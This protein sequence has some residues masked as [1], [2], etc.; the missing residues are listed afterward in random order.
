[1]TLTYQPGVL[2]PASPSGRSL[3][4]SLAHERDPRPALAR[5]REN[6]D[7]QW[8]VVGLGE[9]LVRALGREISGLRVFPALSGS[10]HAI[11]STQQDLW[12]FLRA[13]DRGA[14]F[15]LSRKVFDLLDG[16]FEP[17]DAMDTFSYAGGRDLSGYQDGTAN[18]GPQESLDVA[19]AGEAFAA[20]GSSFVAVQRWV[21]DLKRFFTH[22]VAERDAMIGRRHADNEEIDGAPESSHVKRTAQETFAPTAF[23]VRR[24]QPW[25]TDRGEGL[26]FIAYAA[27]LDPFEQVMR[28]MA[29]L[30]DGIGDALFRFSRPLTGGYYWC[31]PVADGRLDLSLAGI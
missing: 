14:I 30:E 17:S 15:D 3:S 28:R 26:E 27:S 18:P 16:A 13:A 22:S 2:A 9:P 11:P 31:P 29:G 1:M 19:I 6:F 4:F 25:A 7:P 12:I 21:H 10:A 20:P 24:S 5:L 8:G 23:M